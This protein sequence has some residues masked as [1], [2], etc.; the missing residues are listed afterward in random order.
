[1]R[2]LDKAVVGGGFELPGYWVW[3]SSVAKGDDGLYHMFASRWPKRLPFHP[4]WMVASEVVHATAKTAEGPYKFSDVV[5]PARG[6]QYW[7]GRST[8]NPRI[9]RSRGKWVSVYLE[10][11]EGHAASDIDVASVLLDNSVPVAAGVPVTI[12]DH[13][14]DGIPDLELKFSRSALQALVSPGDDSV[15]VSVGGQIGGDCFE[16]ADTIRIVRPIMPAP[17]AGSV[18][19]PRATVNVISPSDNL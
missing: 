15:A 19:T 3:C 14:G 18:L 5:L 16:G 7:D 1:M 13:D 2:R 4:G 6:A 10:P 12:G 11:P 9:V 17:P 8:H